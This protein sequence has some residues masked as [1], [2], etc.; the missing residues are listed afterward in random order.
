MSEVK[1]RLAT[2]VDAGILA[3]LNQDVQRLHA[4]ALPKMFKQPDNTVEVVKD[5]EERMLA[6]PDGR[7]YIAEVEGEAAGYICALIIQR[8]ASPY[9]YASKFIH[10]DQI[11]VKPVFR[12]LGCGRALIQAV[13]DLANAEGIERVTLDTS[14]FNTEAHQ[15]FARMGFE[16]C[17]LRMD[18]YLS[19]EAEVV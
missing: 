4:N 12:H 1:I 3:L 18:T 2:L 7:T 14:A 13:F 17:S 6:N 16:V 19:K 10:I 11:S 5:F 8:P 15:F 9:T